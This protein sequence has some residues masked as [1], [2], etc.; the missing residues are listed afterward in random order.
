MHSLLFQPLSLPRL[1]P[2]PKV[3]IVESQGLRFGAVELSRSKRN[4]NEENNWCPQIRFDISWLLHNAILRVMRE[5]LI[6]HTYHVKSV[7]A[8]QG[9][10]L[11]IG[12]RTQAQRLGAKNCFRSVSFEAM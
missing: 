12:F 11:S 4:G 8:V 7:P 2:V 1:I 6:E 10:E 3:A 5:P 9:R